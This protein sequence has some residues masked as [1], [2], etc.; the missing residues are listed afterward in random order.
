MDRDRRRGASPCSSS[1]VGY[2][3]FP[4]ISLSLAASFGIYG[5]VKKQIGPSVD[6][7]SGL[8]L[9]S[10]W[11]LPIA[12]VQLIVVGTTTGITLGTAGPWHAVLLSLA[13]VVTAIPAPL[14]R[15]RRAARAAGRDRPAAV[16]RADPA[17][18]HRRW[19]LGEPMPLERWIGFGL[20][21]LALT[22]LT[23]DSL[24][25]ARRARGRV[26]CRR[27]HLT[28]PEGRAKVTIQSRYTSLTRRNT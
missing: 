15:R 3:T 12:I 4:W 5:L 16:R 21:W 26:G 22:V 19:L 20:V 6:A 7:V 9:E 25:F 13:G 28:P 27:D 1:C 10:F 17:V 8:T 14:L 24:V 23:V 2:G 11:L 18:R